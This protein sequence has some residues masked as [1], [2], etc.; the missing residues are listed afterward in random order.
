MTLL[1]WE[2]AFDKVDHECLCDALARFGIHKGTIDALKDGYSKAAFYVKDQ[3]RKS[4]KKYQLSGIRQGC[5]LSPYLFIMILTCVEKD[6][7]ANLS[8]EEISKRIPNTDVDMVYYADDTIIVST[9]KKA[10]EKL[11]ELTETISGKYG[12]KLNKAK[13]VNLNM[14]TEEQ[15]AFGNGEALG[16]AQDATYLGNVLNYKADPHAEITRSQPNFMETFRLLE[17]D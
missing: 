14:N 9:D 10:C 2:K 3:F 12:L 8:P 1:D 13:C 17:S 7:Q 15:Q 5:P 11:L 6:I 4:E 16:K